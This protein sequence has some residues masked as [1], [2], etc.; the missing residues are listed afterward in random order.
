VTVR[1]G[2]LSSRRV[3]SADS[4]EGKLLLQLPAPSGSQALPGAGATAR[5]RG[6]GVTSV[7][8]QVEACSRP[9]RGSLAVPVP[10]HVEVD[11]PVEVVNSPTAVATEPPTA[12]PSPATPCRAPKSDAPG[13]S[14]T[15]TLPLLGGSTGVKAADPDPSALCSTPASTAA[16]S[17]GSASYAPSA[18]EDDLPS[19]PNVPPDGTGM[20]YR[21]GPVHE[22]LCRFMRNVR[23]PRVVG[24]GMVPARQAVDVAIGEMV[25]TARSDQPD[26]GGVAQRSNEAARPA[27]DECRGLGAAPPHSAGAAIPMVL[28]QEMA[29]RGGRWRSSDLAGASGALLPEAILAI[30]V[31][32]GGSDTGAAGGRVLQPSSLVSATPK[33]ETGPSKAAPVRGRGDQSARDS[34]N[35]HPATGATDS[36]SCVHT[37][38]STTAPAAGSPSH[39]RQ[40]VKGEPAPLVSIVAMPVQQEPLVAPFSQAAAGINLLLSDDGYMAARGCGCRESV[41]I[42]GAPLERQARGLYFEVKILE[43]VDGWLGGLGIGVTHTPPSELHR[44]PDK[45]WRVPRS[46][47]VGY[48]GCAYLGGQ[49]RRCN[50]RPDMLRVGQMVGLLVTG[51]GKEDLV[52]FVDSVM[53]V[54]IDGALLRDAG[55]CDEHL[56]PIV[57]VYNATLAL[58]LRA[59]AVASAGP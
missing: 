51:D 18:S 26:D 31:S 38:S 49:E 7:H 20:D 14:P 53:T 23:S 48:S 44:V 57:D 52:V 22:P 5:P 32:S 55:L 43:T 54:H 19:A 59:R 16:C 11:V 1:Y 39:R 58:E 42:G 46:F 47:V 25:R 12:P 33:C 3:I 4:P 35:M 56:Y 17:R 6:P 50:W 30:D 28:P 36:R 45:A 27:M 21:S 9:G 37:N 40:A 8:V 24:T 41:A 13:P 29:V 15:Q 10:V 34:A 2:A